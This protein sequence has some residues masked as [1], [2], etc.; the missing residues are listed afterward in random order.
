MEETIAKR[1]DHARKALGVGCM[2]VQTSGVS[3]L[4]EAEQSMLREAVEA[5]SEFGKDN[6]PYGEHDFG[7]ITQNGVDYFWKI[8]NYG[9]EYRQHGL[10][11]PLLLT[12]MRADEY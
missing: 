1:Y 8:D 7:K 10:T 6:D 3:S 5:Y 12:I 11:H 9:D 4:P 2:L